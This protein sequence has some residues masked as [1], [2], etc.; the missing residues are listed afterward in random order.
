[1]RKVGACVLMGAAI[2]STL[3]A[4]QASAPIAVP[5]WVYPLRSSSSG[6]S[7]LAVPTASDSAR[8][9]RVPGSR[10]VYSAAYVRDL[11]VLP[12]W[13]PNEHGPMPEIVARGRKPVVYACGYCHLPDGGGRPENAMLAGLSESYMLAQIAAMRTRARRSGAPVRYL[14]TE[15]MISNLDST[16]TAEIAAAVAYFAKQRPR[17][18]IR[19]RE[20][21]SIPRVLPATGIHRI[22]PAGG[23]ESLDGRIV[24]MPDDPERHEARDAHAT[25]TSYVPVGSLARGRALAERGSLACTTCHGGDLRGSAIA[26]AIAGRPPSYLLRQLLAFRNGARS[27]PEATAMQ[28]VV[29]SLDLDA[30]VAVAGYAGSRKP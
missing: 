15:V 16:T 6:A 11:F 29:A 13:Y 5:A 20:A 17:Q 9:L 23:T 24:E 22:D 7:V 27:T 8:L 1:M 26:P 10:A 18:R 4:Q 30:M 25:Y 2:C 19:V 12:D 14:P 3:T 21:T 28:A